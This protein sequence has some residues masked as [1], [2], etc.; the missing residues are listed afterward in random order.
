MYQQINLAK[1]ISLPIKSPLDAKRLLTF[2]GVFLL[3]LMLVYLWCLLLKNYQLSHHNHLE[4]ELETTKQQ[5]ITTAAK[6]PQSPASMTLLNSS[7]LSSCNTKFSK[8]MEGFAQAITAGVW[9]T[10]IAVTNH[11]K[12]VSLKGFALRATQTEQYLIQLKKLP[13]FKELNFELKE[14]TESINTSSTSTQPLNFQLI[15]K[16]SS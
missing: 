14:L 13:I 8:Y 1:Y 6:Y 11:G 12:E 15:G 4:A 2:Y 10:D 5:L 7:L 9:L 16:A 3:S